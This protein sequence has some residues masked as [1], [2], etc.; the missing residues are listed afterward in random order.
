MPENQSPTGLSTQEAGQRLWQYGPNALEVN[1]VSTLLIFNARVGFW[2]EI[3]A[4]RLVPGSAP[5]AAG[6]KQRRANT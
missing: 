5:I 4:E 3:G 6:P 2:Q 1:K